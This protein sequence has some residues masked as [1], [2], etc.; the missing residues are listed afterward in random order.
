MPYETILVERHAAEH[1]VILS[2][3]LNR[4]E[5]RNAIN[6]QMI[7][8]LSS[9]IDE[10][11]TDRRQT[12]RRAKLDEEAEQRKKAMLERFARD[13]PDQYQAFRKSNERPTQAEI[14]KALKALGD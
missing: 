13:Y 4:P 3:T 9:V 1:G 11:K 5:V 10:L 6:A 12:S 7:E 2:I 8:E 14:E